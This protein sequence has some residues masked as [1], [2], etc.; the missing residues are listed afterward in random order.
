[1]TDQQLFGLYAL[2]IG[3][4]WSYALIYLP[5][6]GMLAYG[7]AGPRRVRRTITQNNNSCN[8]STGSLDEHSE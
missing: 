3:G 4:S 5:G 1:V 6:L 7:L 2:K 8:P